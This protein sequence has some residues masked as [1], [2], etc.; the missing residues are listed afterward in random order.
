[1]LIPGS[2]TNVNGSGNAVFTTNG[3]GVGSHSITATF[4]PTDASAFNSSTSQTPVSVTI[5]AAACQV[6]ADPA[7]GTPARPCGVD[8]QTVD[9]NVPAGSLVISTP[10]GPNH[11]F[12]L[13]DMTLSTDGSQLQVSKGFPETGE[14]LVITDTRAGDLP[15]TASAASTVFSGSGSSTIAQSGLS[16]TGV[17]VQTVASNTLGTAAKPVVPSDI[18]SFTVSPQ[19]FATA[20][21]GNGTVWIVGTL[22]LTAPTSVP[23]GL[24]TA[25]VTFTIA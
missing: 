3:L 11:P 4:T 16:F 10:Y 17:A 8:P 1:V 9:A 22:G 25:T 24:Y 14:H 2:Q 20:A 21:Q 18:A 15:W 23:A 7:S 6:P 5:N 12:H 13:G 19:T